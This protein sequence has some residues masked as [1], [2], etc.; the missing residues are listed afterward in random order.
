MSPIN[1]RLYPKNWKSEIRP[2]ILKRANNC[3]EECGVGNKSV[4]IIQDNERVFLKPSKEMA[5]F[6]LCPDGMKRMVG[7]TGYWTLKR[8]VLTIAHVNH[9]I[10]NND[11]SNL[12]ALCQKCHL[13]LDSIQHRENARK[14][15]QN[16]KGLQSLF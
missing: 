13:S 16:K 14:T 12:K 6:Y 4:Y 9:N 10:Q 3:C 11:P 5:H 2:A 7:R 8:V 1:Y 15:I